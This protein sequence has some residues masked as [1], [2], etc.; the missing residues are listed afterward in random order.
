ME[1]VSVDDIRNYILFNYYARK[2]KRTVIRNVKSEI[3][4]LKTINDLIM[5]LR[6]Y[7][8]I[9]DYGFLKEIIVKCANENFKQLLEKYE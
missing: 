4:N 9:L 7:C 5:E 2:R 8:T 6:W 3:G 1:N